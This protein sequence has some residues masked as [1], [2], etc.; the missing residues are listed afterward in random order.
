MLQRL[1]EAIEELAKTGSATM[2]RMSKVLKNIEVKRTRRSCNARR[3]DRLGGSSW[4]TQWV[5]ASD[6]L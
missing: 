5:D 4:S 1:L 2:E 6:A 3:N